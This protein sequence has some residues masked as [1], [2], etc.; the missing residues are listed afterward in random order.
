[1]AAA[2]VAEAIT[3]GAA[4]WVAEAV[5]TVAVAAPAGLRRSADAALSSASLGALQAAS[6]RSFAAP[7]ASPSRSASRAARSAP[8]GSAIAPC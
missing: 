5:A 2:E 7:I 8:I 3:V 1:M 6:T 4:E